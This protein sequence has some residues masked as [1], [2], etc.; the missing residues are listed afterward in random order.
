MEDMLWKFPHVGKRIFKKLSNKNLVKC[1]EVGR[2]WEYFITHE[3]FYNEKV[4]YELIQKKRDEIGRTP[5]HE[6]AEAGQFPECKMIIDHVENKN[7]QDIRRKNTPLHLAAIYGHVA[8]CQLI[9][10]NIEDKNPENEFGI[11]PFHLAAIHGNFNVCQFFIDKLKDKNPKDK[12]G[13]T[14]LHFAVRRGHFGTCKLIVDQVEDINP[15]TIGGTT[16]LSLAQ[17]N[18]Y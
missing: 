11:T 1:K 7:P 2:S 18:Y 6:A 5:L 15:S 16:P 9:I 10:D 12:A 13:W 8:I 3:K 17:F 14:P 4:K